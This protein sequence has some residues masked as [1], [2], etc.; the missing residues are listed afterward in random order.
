MNIKRQDL[1]SFVSSLPGEDPKMLSKFND[2][3]K[4]ILVLDPEKRLKVE[5]ALSHPFVSG[6]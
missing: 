6:E 1:S 5:Q 2:I 4:R 3:L